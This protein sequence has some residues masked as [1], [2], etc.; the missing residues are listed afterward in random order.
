MDDLNPNVLVT[1][2]VMNPNVLVTA[3]VN[4]INS[5]DSASIIPQR[6]RMSMYSKL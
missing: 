6:L 3:D 2:D 4:H 1:A 5:I